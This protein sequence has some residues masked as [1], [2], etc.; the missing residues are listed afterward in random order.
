V[1]LSAQQVKDQE[2]DEQ[3]LKNKVYQIKTTT[4]GSAEKVAAVE[5]DKFSLTTDPSRTTGQ[6]RHFTNSS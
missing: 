3:I 4:E 5:S 2:I 1:E 6:P